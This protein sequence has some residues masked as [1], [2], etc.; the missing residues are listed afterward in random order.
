MARGRCGVFDGDAF[1]YSFADHVS[2]EAST[3]IGRA[4]N[5][6]LARLP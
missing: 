3:R 6:Y 5:D 2:D 1:L 4:L